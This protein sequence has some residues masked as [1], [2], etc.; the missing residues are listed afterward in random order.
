MNRHAAR[1]VRLA[2]HRALAS[3]QCC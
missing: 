3:G 1:A 2:F